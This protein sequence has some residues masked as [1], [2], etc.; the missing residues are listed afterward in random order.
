MGFYIVSVGSHFPLFSFPFFL[1]FLLLL[2][3]LPPQKQTNNAPLPEKACDT[4]C[5]LKYNIALNRSCHGIV[6]TAGFGI[7]KSTGN[8]LHYS[9]QGPP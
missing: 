3:I 2:Q 6:I 5:S 7:R 1:F 9:F 8:T 4:T